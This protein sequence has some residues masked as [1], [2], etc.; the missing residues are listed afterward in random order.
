MQNR[1]QKNNSKILHVSLVLIL[2]LGIML[3]IAVYLQNRNLI[4]DESNIARNI[5][6]RDFFQLLL[7]LSYEQYAPPVFLWILKL[8]SVLFGFSEYSLR[9]YALLTGISSLF[10]MY[11]LLKEFVPA[12]SVWYALF[13]FATAHILLRYS[14]EVKQYMG[15]VLIVLTLLLLALRIHVKNISPVKFILFWATAGTIAIWLSMPS[16]FAL[17]GI[18]IYYTAI[19]IQQKVYNKI[20]LLII[21][22]AV[23]LMQF[24]FYYIAILKDQANSA[25]LQNF[26]RDNF[27]FAT[28]EDLHEVAQNWAIFSALLRQFGNNNPFGFNVVFNT[29]LLLS[30][31]FLLLKQNFAKALLLLTPVVAVLMA[32]ALNDFS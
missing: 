27:L 25:Y 15:D 6:E 17:A 31:I 9:L 24:I 28:P 32:S 7:P 22:A 19:C 16:V 18:G 13:L 8:S 4:I 1:F 30:G 3:R 14:S 11:L 26:H 21:C 10:V 12:R 2:L 20:R 23:W 5:F 29:L